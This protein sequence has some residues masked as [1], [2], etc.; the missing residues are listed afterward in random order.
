MAEYIDRDM[1]LKMISHKPSSPTTDREDRLIN[2]FISAVKNCPAADVRPVV[3]AK[4]EDVH[5][6]R[7]EIADIEVATMFC[8]HCNRWHNE[9][10]HYGNPI[11]FAN[12]CSFCGASMKEES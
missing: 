11:E 7:P 4:W 12:Y 6:D 3:K 10:Y 5:I 9:V 8:P 1:F 2:G